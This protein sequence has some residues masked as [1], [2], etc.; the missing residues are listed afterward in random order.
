MSCDLVTFRS[1]DTISSPPQMGRESEWSHTQ[2]T[3]CVH[4]PIPVGYLHFHCHQSGQTQM[5]HPDQYQST[6]DFVH[7]GLSCCYWAQQHW[8]AVQWTWYFELGNCLGK[9]AD[10]HGPTRTRTRGKPIPVVRVQVWSR[11]YKIEPVPVPTTGTGTKPAGFT[12]GLSCPWSPTEHDTQVQTRMQ[13]HSTFAFVFA[14]EHEDCIW[15]KE[16]HL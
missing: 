11:V 14:Y 6:R 9:P 13:T 2:C 10:T 8:L 16:N 1:L 5:L 15:K 7:D 3:C 12:C 4:E